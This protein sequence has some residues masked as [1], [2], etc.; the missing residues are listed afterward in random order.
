M[1]AAEDHPEPDSADLELALTKLAWENP[2]AT[3]DAAATLAA[4]GVDIP[5]G[6]RVDLRVQRPDTLYLVIPP[7]ASA[8]EESEAVVNQMDLWRSGEQFVWVMPQEAKMALL[9]MR[10]QFRG[11]RTARKHERR[12]LQ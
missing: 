9:E 6:M 8:V 2:S 11:E 7:A 5:A 4:L 12:P 3:V 10:A 1:A